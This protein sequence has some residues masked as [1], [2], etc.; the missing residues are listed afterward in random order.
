MP[1]GLAVL[2]SSMMQPKPGKK[3]RAGKKKKW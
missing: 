3:K 2:L 1:L